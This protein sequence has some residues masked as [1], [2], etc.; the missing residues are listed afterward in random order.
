M[1]T[2]FPSRPVKRHINSLTCPICKCS[3]EGRPFNPYDGGNIEHCTLRCAQ[4]PNHY[5]LELFWSLETQPIIVHT[6][7][8]FLAITTRP[9]R[10]EIEKIFKDDVPVSTHI[11]LIETD[12]DGAVLPGTSITSLDI[13]TNAVEFYPYDEEKILRRIKTI[14][15]FG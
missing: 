3:L 12:G 5:R 15:L 10:F 1:T 9:H 4:K 6:K 11:R 8:E 2:L 14:L 13:E 7:I